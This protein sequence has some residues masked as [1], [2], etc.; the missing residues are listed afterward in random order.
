MLAAIGIAVFGFWPFIRRKNCL[1]IWFIIVLITSNID[2]INGEPNKSCEYSVP[3]VKSIPDI[4]IYNFDNLFSSFLPFLTKFS[5]IPFVSQFF[6]SKDQ[7][8]TLCKTHFLQMIYRKTDGTVLWS[9]NERNLDCALTFQTHSI[10]QRFMLRFDT[11][12]LDCNDHLYIYD[13]AH[14]TGQAKVT[15]N[16]IL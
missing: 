12:Q 13:G 2:Y 11:L 15:F 5:F 10:L 16:T 8:K 1:F 3:W 4:L 6:F 7:M 9:Q 14:A